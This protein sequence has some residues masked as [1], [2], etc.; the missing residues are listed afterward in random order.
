MTQLDVDLTAEG[1]P[2]RKRRLAEW[3]LRL[4]VAWLM[5]AARRFNDWVAFKHRFL[6]LHTFSDA[7]RIDLDRDFVEYRGWRCLHCEEPLGW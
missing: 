5:F 2:Y 1:L 4:L 6:G 3:R 7:L